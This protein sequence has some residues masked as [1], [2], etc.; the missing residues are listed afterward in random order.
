MDLQL[1]VE[2]QGLTAGKQYNLYRYIF[3]A[4][5]AQAGTTPVGTHVALAVPRAGF[6]GKRASATSAVSF[7]ATGSTYAE[8]LALRSDRVAVFR[9]VPVE[10]P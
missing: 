4:V 8:T 7:T 3:D 6:N 9:A 2:V 1:R 10:A 5:T